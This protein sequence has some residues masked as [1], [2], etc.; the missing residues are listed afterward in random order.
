[1]PCPT[2]WNSNYNSLS[3]VRD[4]LDTQPDAFNKLLED[5]T[6]SHPLSPSEHSAICSYVGV[7][8]PMC[9]AL[10]I[11]QGE[12]GD[13]NR[14]GVYMGCL[15]PYLSTT[16]ELTQ[17]CGREFPMALE[18]SAK[19]V[20]QIQMRFMKEFEDRDLK[21]AA[22][23]HPQ[24]RLMWV[25]NARKEAEIKETMIEE[26]QRH[27]EGLARPDSGGSGGEGTAESNIREPMSV[28][29][30][31]SKPIP[32]RR[33]SFV[34]DGTARADI[35]TYFNTCQGGKN[36]TNQLLCPGIRELFI[37]FNTPIPSS[38]A[39][40]RLFSVGRDILRPK[41]SSMSDGNFDRVMFLRANRKVL[42]LPPGLSQ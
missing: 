33:N 3:L 24:F 39:V 38:A 15:L 32:P 9:Q 41:R 40:E 30:T 17:R 36:W 2:R 20:D 18:L 34:R 8:T 25:K 14:D 23:F 13:K 29:G 22:A 31:F 10:D 19:V 16:I 11:L 28:L 1:V 6:H 35:E 21:L 4:M 5:V 37:K 7:M 26:L 27:Y 12:G 42:P